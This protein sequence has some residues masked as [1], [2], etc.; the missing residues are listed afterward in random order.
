M[1]VMSTT[2][3][4][5]VYCANGFLGRAMVPQLLG[6]GFSVRALVRNVAAA[7]HLERLGAEVVHADLDDRAGLRDAHRDVDVALVQLPSGDDAATA[8]RR[9]DAALEALGRARIA[10]VVFNASV[11]SP[12][13]V[14]ELPTFAVRRAFAADLAGVAQNWAVI[15]PTFCLQNLLLPW[16]TAAVGQ[17][18]IVYPVPSALKLSWVAAEDVARMT[19]MVLAERRFGRTIDLGGATALDGDALAAAFADALGRPVRFVSL[20]LDE[21]ER[22]VDAA[23]GS[24]TGKR[25]SAIFRFIERHPSDL[26][27]VTT[28]FRPAPGFE[29]FTPTPVVEWVRTHAHAFAADQHC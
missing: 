18:A 5:L 28:P 7:G 6:A 10:T 26:A 29:S 4:I 27:F 22:N 24:R 14:E 17:G 2:N 15:R 1:D 3:K 20:D 13:H 9:A 19:V 8:R 16:V 23:L 25:I 21:F 12:E 11:Q